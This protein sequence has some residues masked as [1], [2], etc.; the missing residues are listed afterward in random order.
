MSAVQLAV[1]G[2]TNSNRWDGSQES[3]LRAELY[4]ALLPVVGAGKM[5]GAA[6][7]L[8]RLERV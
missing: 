1:I 2:S 7:A 5:V 8:L 4:G 3:A 6:N